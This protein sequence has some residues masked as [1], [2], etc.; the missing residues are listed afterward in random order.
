MSSPMSSTPLRT[1]ESLLDLARWAP[2]GD[3]TQP[4]RFRIHAPD[5]VAIH[6]FDTRTHCVY[7]L[8]GHASEMAHGALL[9]TLRIAAAEH[10]L[11]AVWRA[12]AGTPTGAPV[13][14]V[15]LDGATPPARDPLAAVIRARVTH[16]RPYRLR[17]LSAGQ[18]AELEA[19]VQPYRV[20]W[21]TR[22]GE[23]LAMARLLWANAHLRL[24]LPEAFAVHR[25]VIEWRVRYSE[26]RIPEQAV[27]AD[28]IMARLMRVLMRDWRRVDFANRYLAGTVLP[29]IELDLLPALA[30]GAHACLL[31]P[32]PPTTAEDFVAAGVAMQRFWL[33]ATR[34]GLHMQPEMTP[35]IFARYVRAGLRFS[36]D[37]VKWAEAETLAARFDTALHARLAAEPEAES[38]RTAPDV[39]ARAVVLCRLGHARAPRSRSLRRPLEALWQH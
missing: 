20:V 37:P 27:G 24:T 33:C 15:H 32:A 12:R 22:F 21:W 36:P 5:H 25:S 7:D 28:P 38:E 17:A 39:A 3:N 10:G 26:D 14:D 1:L 11:A 2:S 18:R 29:R 8:D 19:A 16:R 6:G 13:Y 23:R 30:C 34:L 9:E 31:A 4:W 35:L